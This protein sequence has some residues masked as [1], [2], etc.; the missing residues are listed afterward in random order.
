[1]DLILFDSKQGVYLCE[2]KGENLPLVTTKEE[3]AWRVPEEKIE[4]AW[5]MAYRAS[6]FGIGRF[7]VYG[8]EKVD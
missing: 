4:V 5:N 6:W 1:M 2:P 3:C 7:Y 8:I